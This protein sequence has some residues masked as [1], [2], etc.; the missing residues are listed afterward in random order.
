VLSNTGSSFNSTGVT[1][2]GLDVESDDEVENAVANSLVV[3][4]PAASFP[5][6]VTGVTIQQPSATRVQ[7]PTP[8]QKP[9]ASSSVRCGDLYNDKIQRHIY[10]LV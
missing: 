6:P 2:S 7:Q 5:K 1:G 9:A 4:P 10:I 8:S 3:A